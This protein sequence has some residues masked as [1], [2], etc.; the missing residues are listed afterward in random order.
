LREGRAEAVQ[1]RRGSF[2]LS[3]GRLSSTRTDVKQRGSGRRVRL[4]GFPPHPPV[5]RLRSAQ[6]RERMQ[7]EGNDCDYEV[8]SPWSFRTGRI[9]GV[10]TVTGSLEKS[11]N[12]RLFLFPARR[13]R[14][15]GGIPPPKIPNHAIFYSCDSHRSRVQRRVSLLVDQDICKVEIIPS[16]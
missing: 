7:A 15:G 14:G 13:G 4:D 2:F 6:A 16:H 10:P 12:S 8:G 11:E 9:H 3:A 1:V 5:A